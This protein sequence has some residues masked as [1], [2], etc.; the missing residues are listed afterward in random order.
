MVYEKIDQ[1]RYLLVD[2][3][4]GAKRELPFDGQAF[5][6]SL[7]RSG[8]PIYFELVA[9]RHSRICAFDSQNNKLET[10]VGR[11]LD[12]T[13][14]AI[15]PDGA[16]LAFVS[17]GKLGVRQ[18]GRLAWPVASTAVS[19]PAFYPHGDRIVFADGRP[20]LRVLRS[21]AL[22]GGALVALTTSGDSFAPAISPDGRLLAYVASASGER[23]VW[24]LD[25]AIGASRPLTEGH[26]QNDAPAW[27]P[28]SGA[29]VFAS[30][31]DRGLGL[32]SLFVLPVH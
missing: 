4:G 23:Q 13:E 27:R 14:P 18:A 21:V 17:H 9:G 12:P 3:Q 29:V 26:C 31:C 10:V 22:T 11:E 32:P 15:S 30:D 6:P 16:K 1:E 5:H 28:D 25:L 2:V 19:D 20:G 7:P 24:I 8:E